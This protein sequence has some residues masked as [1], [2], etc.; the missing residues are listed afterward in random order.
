M[1]SKGSSLGT[2]LELLVTE[3]ERFLRTT[4]DVAGLFGAGAAFFL[5]FSVP[6]TTLGSVN[7]LPKLDVFCPL[8]LSR[9]S[10]F[11]RDGNLRWLDLDGG[12]GVGAFLVW[13]FV[14]LFLYK[15]STCWSNQSFASL[16]KCGSKVFSSVFESMKESC[17]PSATERVG[18]LTWIRSPRFLFVETFLFFFFFAKCVLLYR[19]AIALLFS[20]K[21]R[22]FG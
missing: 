1:V 19:F 17:S 8:L 5:I 2:V 7:V 6:S 13:Y 16:S 12:C 21:A 10:A 4:G 20:N 15:F 3:L 9:F 14:G 18:G 22:T 11:C